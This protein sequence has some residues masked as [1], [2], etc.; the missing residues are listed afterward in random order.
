[1]SRTDSQARGAIIDELM[2]PFFS[3]P[4]RTRLQILDNLDKAYRA[5]QDAAYERA[6]Q[7]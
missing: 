2:L 5:G 1:M 7:L 3:L 4:E 6:A